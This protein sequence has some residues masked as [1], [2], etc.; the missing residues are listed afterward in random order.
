MG[1]IKNAELS[2]CERARAHVQACGHACNVW[3]QNHAFSASSVI[4]MDT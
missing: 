4:E 1:E 2:V 3:K